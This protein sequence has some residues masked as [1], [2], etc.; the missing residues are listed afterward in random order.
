[1]KT[2]P[3]L[4]ICALITLKLPRDQRYFKTAIT[5]TRVLIQEFTKMERTWILLRMFSELHLS[6]ESFPGKGSMVKTSLFIT[7]LLPPYRNKSQF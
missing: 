3:F 7:A 2:T 1:M 4:F 5:Q 6:W